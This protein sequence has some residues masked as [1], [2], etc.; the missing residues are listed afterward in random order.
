MNMSNAK[1]ILL[2]DDDADDRAMFQD[3]VHDADALCKCVVMSSAERA[4]LLLTA[5]GATPDF[6][7]LDLNM[8]C[9]NGW[10][11]LT[12]LRALAHLNQV[13]VILYST[14]RRKEDVL[15]AEK[16][17]AT[18]FLKKPPRYAQ[19]VQALRYVLAGEWARVA[20]LDYPAM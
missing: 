14:C 13:P 20:E 2:I 6:I 17:G 1:T 11:C 8:P 9:L 4:L 3:A 12:R 16:M 15:K 5:Q 7:F 18:C 10:Q 19:L